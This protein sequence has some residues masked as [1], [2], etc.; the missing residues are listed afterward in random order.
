MNKHEEE[1]EDQF[2]TR[3][4]RE[5]SPYF[6]AELRQRLNQER[7]KATMIK[8]VSRNR[9]M[10]VSLA[11]AAMI[12]IAALLIM[13]ETRTALAQVLE[14]V[15]AGITFKQAD[16]L[17]QPGVSANGEVIVEQ[18]APSFT[19][20]LAEIQQEIPF[21]MPRTV[22]SGFVMEPPQISYFGQDTAGTEDDFILAEVQWLKND[23]QG[24]S[25][26]VLSVT[27]HDESSLLVGETS[28]IEERLVAGRPVAVYR[29][30]WNS[31][32]GAFE[33]MGIV[34]ISWEMD[35]L[36]YHLNSVADSVSIN[37][38]VMIAESV[39]EQE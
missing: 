10:A 30:G 35:G 33:D 2:L 27:D 9:R 37:T 12:L 31:E 13:P 22:P 17:P 34:N 6:A 20:E 15:V 39:I 3:Y 16:A 36:N 14:Q 18:T 26:F 24:L 25:G 7:G 21:V 4:Q 38:L 23:G 28:H 29:G 8:N 32:T 19:A 11:A 5:P 1:Y